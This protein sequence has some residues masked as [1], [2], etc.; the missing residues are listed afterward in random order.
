[1]NEE[2]ALYLEQLSSL[3]DV[4]A[5]LQH[6]HNDY[7]D[8]KAKLSVVATD[9]AQVHRTHKAKLQKDIRE[10]RKYIRLGE[11]LLE[12]TR[13][14]HEPPSEELLG[15]LAAVDQFSK[16]AKY[17]DWVKFLNEAVKFLDK[18]Q[19][20]ETWRKCLPI[21]D[22]LN[23]YASLME[24]TACANLKRVMVAECRKRYKI[25]TELA[26]KSFGSVNWKNI[27]DENTPETLENVKFLFKLSEP[28]CHGKPNVKLGLKYIF[29]HF[30]LQFKFHFMRKVK[31]NDIKKP[32]WYFTKLLSWIREF[33]DK[34]RQS[35][36]SLF[37]NENDATITALFVEQFCEL[38]VLK[39]A[40]DIPKLDDGLFTHYIDEVIKFHK[41]LKDHL[42]LSHFKSPIL[43]LFTQEKTLSRWLQL[44]TISSFKFL[45]NV[46]KDATCFEERESGS[47]YPIPSMCV[48][49][50]TSVKAVGERVK[51][52]PSLA[53]NNSFYS[54]QCDLLKEFMVHL[55][56]KLQR[57]DHKDAKFCL[58][59]NSVVYI[60]SV[61]EEWSYDQHYIKVSKFEG[62]TAPFA[63]ISESYILLQQDVQDSLESSISS[64]V[65]GLLGSYYKSSWILP[66]K[67]DSISPSC[68]AGLM[69]LQQSLSNLSSSLAPDNFLLIWSNLAS[70]FQLNFT[71]KFLTK[72]QFNLA[73]AQQFRS[74]M[75]AF[76]GIFYEYCS[77]SYFNKLNSD[78]EILTLPCET[79]RLWK[80]EG[81]NSLDNLIDLLQ[82][83][84]ITLPPSEVLKI[85][86]LRADI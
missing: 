42:P 55:S 43:H 78:L 4:P 38:A 9:T 21:Y 62:D 74:D 6:F 24:D 20:K 81:Y 19:T 18:R 48:R 10:A 29:S 33:K 37:E 83:R 57:L 31:T 84:G 69:E 1:M 16:I 34:F 36:R 11:D 75:Q 72:S 2:E 22:E 63:H 80:G 68:S 54:L 50:L 66:H 25:L 86:K 61:L 26:L 13:S 76:C 45:E 27:N 15:K 5:S 47:G 7:E 65:N 52:F 70:S 32:E 49:V 23:C 28:L 46:E 41:E 51:V 12:N 82:E 77:P 30:E 73:G 3:S 64:K 35:F 17:L 58:I 59:L 60:L 71:N 79:A 8:A 40:D 67:L 85:L 39:L 44:E 14:V 56:D 53:L